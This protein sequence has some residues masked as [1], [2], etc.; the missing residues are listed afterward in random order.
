M[1]DAKSTGDLL[2]LL[3]AECELL[4]DIER[5]GPNHERFDL[6]RALLPD[7]EARID[8]AFRVFGFTNIAETKARLTLPV[9]RMFRARQA[10]FEH[11]LEL[12]REEE[13]DKH[14]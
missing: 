14:K 3:V 2:A 8:A 1:A 5:L 9:Q 10:A 11:I 7:V 12:A 6:M 4:A 13:M